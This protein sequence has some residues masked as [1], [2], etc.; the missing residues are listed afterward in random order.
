MRKFLF[1]IKKTL[2]PASD[3]QYWNEKAT[4]LAYLS[5][6]H[7]DEIVEDPNLSSLSLQERAVA[8]VGAV[9]F[10]A[11]LAEMEV[12][13]S[14]A[15]LSS[16]NIALAVKYGLIGTLI[17]HLTNVN[18]D[19]IE[20]IL[21]KLHGYF[22]PGNARSP[23]DYHTGAKHRYT[24]GHDGNIFQKLPGGYTIGGKS[25]GDKTLYDLVFD[26]IKEGYPQS[27][28]IAAHVKAIMHIFTHLM[29]D[30]PTKDGIPLPF[31]SIFTKW[32]ENPLNASGYSASNPVMDFLGREFGTIN[33][34]DVTAL[35]AI[36]LLLKT[37]HSIEFHNS[38]AE[39][40]DKELL[41]ALMSSI[42]YGTSVVVQMFI[43]IVDPSSRTGKLNHLI[44]WPFLYNSGKAS[45]MLYQQHKG[46]ID[47]YQSSIALLSSGSVEFEAWVKTQ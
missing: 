36:K 7:A 28:P 8:A 21:L 41:L 19:K 33:A 38:T 47:S 37:H 22:K 35:A 4:E 34:A 25:V 3:E 42:A 40:A 15:A 45:I 44:A 14:Y 10:E 46:L 39:E 17:G 23:L 13:T 27:G 9:N 1:S 12:D 2:T 30:L 16:V 29:S 5:K 6:L 18:A 24:F 31:T 32:V 11:L 20:E 43:M 26:Y